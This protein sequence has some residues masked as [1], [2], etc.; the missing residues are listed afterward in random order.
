VHAVFAILISWSTRGVP[1]PPPIMSRSA[2]ARSVKILLD[3]SNSFAER[4][5]NERFRF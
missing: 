3:P 4:V 1:S 2:K 5:L